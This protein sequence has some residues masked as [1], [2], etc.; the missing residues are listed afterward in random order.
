MSWCGEFHATRKDIASSISDCDDRAYTS[1]LRT[2]LWRTC[3][4]ARTESLSERT[5]RAVECSRIPQARI[6]VDQPARGAL[7]PL[8][9]AEEIQI[10][11]D[12]MGC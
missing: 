12:G 1:V 11:R 4:R 5:T 2:R 8:T 7:E 6:D 10:L 3:G 9:K